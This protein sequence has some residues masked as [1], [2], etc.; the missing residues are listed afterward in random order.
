[1]DEICTEIIELLKE[2]CN[3]TNDEIEILNK[4]QNIFDM[5]DEQEFNF[6]VEILVILV[7]MALKYQS[8]AN[9]IKICYATILQSIVV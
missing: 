4:C 1:M 5:D 6:D 9:L 3:L 8:H 2:Q 7:D